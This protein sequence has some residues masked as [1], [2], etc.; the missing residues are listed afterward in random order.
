MENFRYE[1]AREARASKYGRFFTQQFLLLFWGERGAEDFLKTLRNFIFDTK[2][3]SPSASADFDH[4]QKWG[5]TFSN[6]ANTSREY[7]RIKGPTGGIGIPLC[8]R[9][10]NQAV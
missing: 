7:V 9:L 10:G 1:L 3:G 5:A 2:V 8:T 6:Y 4:L